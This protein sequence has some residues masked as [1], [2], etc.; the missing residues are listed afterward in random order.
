[1]QKIYKNS[2]SGKIF[3]YIS[4]FYYKALLPFEVKKPRWKMW[5]YEMLYTLAK[6][7]DYTSSI[8]FPFKDTIIQ[9]KFGVFKIRPDTSDAANVSPAFE[10]RDVNYLLNLIE[11]LLRQNKKILFCDIGADLGG[12]SVIVANAFPGE[13]IT[14]KCFEPIEESCMLIKEN[15]VLNNAQHS[16]ELYPVAVMDQDNPSLAI[17]LNMTTPGS[18][19]ILTT[20]AYKTKECVVQAKKL[21]SV[22][23]DSITHYDAVILKIDVEGVEQQVLDGARKIIESRKEIYAMVEDFIDPRIITYLQK[24]SWDF[25][26]KVT[27]YNSWWSYRGVN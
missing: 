12:Y 15:L 16:V 9:T 19:S 27:S 6:F 22:L 23:L 1:M 26:A 17:Q 8:P 21:D 5:W 20:G 4:Y 13:K 7:R 24:N 14:I 2:T 25:L 3:F 18:S 10:R 11:K